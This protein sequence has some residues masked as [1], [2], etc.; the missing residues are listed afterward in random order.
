MSAQLNKTEKQIKS[1][2]LKAESGNSEA[3]EKAYQMALTDKKI[4]E[5][6]SL[7]SDD[8]NQFSILLQNQMEVRLIPDQRGLAETKHQDFLISDYLAIPWAIHKIHQEPYTP[9]AYALS[10][11]YMNIGNVDMAVKWYATAFLMA[12]IDASRCADKTARQ[13]VQIIGSL[14]ADVKKLMT[15]DVLDR[16]LEFALKKEEEF[17]VRKE[18]KWI[19]SH[20]IQVFLGELKY[21][22]EKE[23]MQE[24]EV[25]REKYRGYSNKN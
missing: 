19:C 17:K 25:I 14:F 16:A 20:G 7:E 21:K 3:I 4:S 11:R 13:E 5:L 6:N 9:Y 2:I 1:L 15:N 24:R 22:D 18:P 12:K 8:P 23:W 10:R